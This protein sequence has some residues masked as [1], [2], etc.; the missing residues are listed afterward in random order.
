MFL[1]ILK[2]R[3]IDTILKSSCD[4]FKAVFGQKEMKK[5]LK[6]KKEKKNRKEDRNWFFLI[7]K[8]FLFF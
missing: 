2:Y 8:K 1:R 7:S 4:F 6:K 5:I 3:G